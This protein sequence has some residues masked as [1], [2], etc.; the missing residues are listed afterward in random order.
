MHPYDDIVR[1]I[2]VQ[3]WRRNVVGF[4]NETISFGLMNYV[5]CKEIISKRRVNYVK[6][7]K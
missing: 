5:F 2:N 4:K 3:K 7:E 6:C 1:T